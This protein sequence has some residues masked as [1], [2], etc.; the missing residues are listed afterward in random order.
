MQV[1]AARAE[2]CPLKGHQ[3]VAPGSAPS[4]EHARKHAQ[5]AAPGSAHP[6]E[7]L[8]RGKELRMRPTS[9]APALTRPLGHHD[10]EKGTWFS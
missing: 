6:V 1:G 2:P 9:W 10:K 3:T 8:E 5:A 4:A 7:L